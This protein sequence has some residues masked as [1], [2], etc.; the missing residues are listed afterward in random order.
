MRIRTVWLLATALA[1]SIAYRLQAEEPTT[2]QAATQPAPAAIKAPSTLEEIHKRRGELAKE[3]EDKALTSTTLP[4]ATQPIRPA[5]QPADVATNLWLLIREY[6]ALLEQQEVQR[7]RLDE[8]NSDQSISDLKAEIDQV[9]ADTKE[10]ETKLETDRAPHETQT[11]KQVRERYEKLNRTHDAQVNAKTARQERLTGIAERRK[12]ANA[13]AAEAR[14]RVDEVLKEFTVRTTTAKAGP[15]RNGLIF[16]RRLAELS[17]EKAL[18]QIESLNI[19]EQ[20]LNQEQRREER[21]LAALTPHVQALRRWMNALEKAAAQSEL[22][23]INANIEAAAR[24]GNK[25]VELCW[26]AAKTIQEAFV[27]FEAY[28]NKTRDLF[29]ES[30]LGKLESKITRAEKY[31][32]N[33]LESLPRRSGHEVL[34]RYKKVQNDLRQASDEKG[35][36]SGKLDR[37]IEQREDVYQLRDKVMENVDHAR[38]RIEDLSGESADERTVKLQA[39][40][41]E[42]RSKLIDRMDGIVSLQ[43]ALI[44]RLGEATRKNAKYVA[45]LE[46]TRSR[47]YWSYLVVR[48]LGLASLEVDKI[49]KEWQGQRL[50][51]REAF[52]SVG[53]EA[54]QQVAEAATGRWALSAFFLLASIPVAWWLRR[55]HSAQSAG[56]ERH[57]GELIQEEGIVA[58]GISERLKLAGMRF[59]VNTALLICPLLAILLGVLILGLSGVPL[60]LLSAVILFVLCMCLGFGVVGASFAPG[61]P[62]FRLIRCSNRVAQYYR[63]WL[64][65]L[66]YLTIVGAPLPVLLLIVDV[67][68]ITR[69]YLWQLYKTLALL[70]ALLFL[71]R[72]Q[73]VLKVVGRPEELR[74]RWLYTMVASLFPLIQLGTLALLVVEILGYDALTSYVIRNVVLTFALLLAVM[75]LTRFANDLASKYQRQLARARQE[76]REAAPDSEAPAAAA[77]IAE[78][79][80]QAGRDGQEAP[81]DMG[82]ELSESEFF[83]SLAAVVF[84]WLVRL[85]GLV[86]ILSVW[87]IR[88]VEIQSALT[89]PLAGSDDS[90]VTLW[91][92]LATVLVIVLTIVV[93]RFI[94]SVLSKRVYPA[95]GAL[96]RGARAAINTLLHYVLI[97]IGF[98]A[99]LQLLHVNL[100]ALTVL[101]GTVGLGL[102]LGLQPLF[103]NFISGLM[104]FFERH[105]KIGDIVEVGDRIGEVTAI[106][107]RSTAIKT[108]DNIDMIIPNAEFI[109]AQVINWSLQDRRV[110]GNL[111]VGVA[112]GSDTEL[113][114]R[115]LLQAARQHKKVLR[116]PEPN[117]WFMDFGDN[118]LVFR[119]NVWVEDLSDRI[120]TLTD[121]RFT[122]DALFAQ[123]GINIPF[124]Q[125]TLSMINDEP[126]RVELMDRRAGAGEASNKREVSDLKETREPGDSH[127]APPA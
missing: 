70:L 104:I 98:Y 57:L 7:K 85:A 74:S 79:P 11:I 69:L 82:E 71:L 34:I 31:W 100:G 13:A 77:A 121:L 107:M 53:M 49:S 81:A 102:G 80:E 15:E 8:L 119:L 58:V 47:L 118:A 88:L 75:V 64:R 26:Q 99:A 6:D 112:Y 24:S 95:Y 61:R 97:V 103:I 40:L 78:A 72:K 127:R 91:R 9:R 42:R 62:R 122:I 96:D 14:K 46:V 67:L 101:L 36:L 111:V 1:L 45:M 12:A 124:P 113:V 50:K 35:R 120:S 114:R 28:D 83:A 22:D 76:E 17:A 123:H 126:L 108:F 116:D 20:L 110:R 109:T 115:L 41:D 84:N 86:L 60:R 32:E 87:G 56:Y 44:K 68:P 63:R 51:I 30:E 39:Q 5:T 18:A 48:D 38:E 90:V 55:R 2:T 25:L 23:R 106:S 66:L 27:E 52:S 29:P 37:S 4:T 21:R 59:L 125:R 65:G 10:L 19:E 16:E 117:V 94:R 43:D 3:I 105:I 54:R 33:F 73:L 93:S 92:V 89:Y